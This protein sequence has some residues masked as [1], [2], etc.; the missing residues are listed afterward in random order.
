[1]QI[2]MRWVL[3]I[4]AAA[5]SAAE[6]SPC[7]VRIAR[8]P[9]EVRV[10]IE[11][12][13]AAERMCGLPLE[14]RVVPTEGGYYLFARD[15]SGGV[16]ERIVPDAQSAGVLVA[17]WAADDRPQRFA[18]P[19]PAIEVLPPIAVLVDVRRDVRRDIERSDGASSR[20]PR[21]WLS[22]GATL[23]TEGGGGIGLRGEL[24]VSTFGPWTLGIA[25]GLSESYQDLDGMPIDGWTDTFGGMIARDYHAVGTLA[26][27]SRFGAWEVRL[28][29][30]AGAVKTTA[31][32]F[33]HSATPAGPLTADGVFPT[34]E[35]GLLLSRR[36]GRHWAIGAGVLATWVDQELDTVVIDETQLGGPTSVPMQVDRE[37]PEISWFAALR[38][39]L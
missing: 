36:L 31:E 7:D 15:P 25:A 17:S 38:H 4:L 14:V 3:P 18:P 26:R 29:V 2:A 28:S 22:L 16:R 6:A 19:P 35:G 37:G 8:A 27:T 32:G 1:M 34:A 24:D 39:R 9:D 30:G 13:V 12:W 5:S 11:S 23:R 21:R 10:E 33:I 20:R